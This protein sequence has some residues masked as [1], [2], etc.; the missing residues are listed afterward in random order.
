MK[1]SCSNRFDLQLEAVNVSIN[2]FWRQVLVE[3]ET[4]RTAAAP[5]VGISVHI[6]FPFPHQHTSAHL[7]LRSWGLLWL[8]QLLLAKLAKFI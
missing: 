3:H 4:T 2:T 7:T 8:K 6:P 1:R 5:L